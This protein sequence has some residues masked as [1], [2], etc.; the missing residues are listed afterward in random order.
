[1]ILTRNLNKQLNM[2]DSHSMACFEKSERSL[3]QR[4]E[5]H[6]TYKNNRLTKIIE[7]RVKTIS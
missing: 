6:M 2:C 3:I 1:M 4:I 5:S 7:K